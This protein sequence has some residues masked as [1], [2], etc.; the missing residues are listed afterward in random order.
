GS[1]P[2]AGSPRRR[3]RRS[4]SPPR[5]S[6]RAGCGGGTRGRPRSSAW[7]SQGPLVLAQ[8][9][10]RRPLEP[11]D[12][13]LGADRQAAPARAEGER[14]DPVG[15]ELDGQRLERPA[16]APIRGRKHGA[17]V[18]DDPPLPALHD[19]VVER[20]LRHRRRLARPGGTAV[21]GAEDDAVDA[22]RPALS[23]VGEVHAEERRLDRRV[24]LAERAAAVVARHDGAELAHHQTWSGSAYE[25]A[26]RFTS[27]GSTPVS[28]A[29]A[30]S[31]TSGP[32]R[33]TVQVR[34]P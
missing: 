34:P 13:P 4:S 14:A 10:E 22:D 18:A 11:Q 28:S 30:G 9:A 29:L 8:A 16:G 2:S 27:P 15:G 19:D 1:P 32:T 17:R 23:R 12:E 33:T 6:P 24:L 7:G 20:A 21:L 26:Y 25:I 5:S 3:R 31:S